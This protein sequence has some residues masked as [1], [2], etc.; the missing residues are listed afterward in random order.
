VNLALRRQR[1]HVRI[2]SGAPPPKYLPNLLR[3]NEAI[4][5]VSTPRRGCGTK[6]TKSVADHF[7]PLAKAPCIARVALPDRLNP[8]AYRL[9][10]PSVPLVSSDIGCELG[11][12]ILAT[13][14][15]TRCQFAARMLMP[16]AAVNK[17]TSL[18]LGSTMFGFP[19]KSRRCSRNRNPIAR[20]KT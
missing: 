15:G 20:P 5:G 12:P 10:L 7:N 3:E 16:E 6:G 13:R 14:L 11:S 9:K 17:T 1:S 8:P 19:G 2:V 4:V 18:C